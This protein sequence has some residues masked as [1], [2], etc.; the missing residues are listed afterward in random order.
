M[1]AWQEEFAS[2]LEQRDVNHLHR[3]RIA[4]K[5][6]KKLSHQTGIN[7]LLADAAKIPETWARWKPMIEQP[8]AVAS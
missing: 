5:W 7:Q 8:A 2:A 4:G 6:K 1:N 3:L